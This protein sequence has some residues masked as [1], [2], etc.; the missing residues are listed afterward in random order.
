MERGRGRSCRRR[1]WVHGLSSQCAAGAGVGSWA[2][3]SPATAA[4]HDLP[5]H[6]AYAS[7]SCLNRA[8]LQNLRRKLGPISSQRCRS[9][10]GEPPIVAIEGQQVPSSS[11]CLAM[12]K[13]T[14]IST[15]LRVWSSRMMF[16][17]SANGRRRRSTPTESLCM[18]PSRGVALWTYS[19]ADF[20]LDSSRGLGYS[21]IYWIRKQPPRGDK[22]GPRKTRGFCIVRL[23]DEQRVLAIAVEHPSDVGSPKS[24]A[25]PAPWCDPLEA[26]RIVSTGGKVSK[27]R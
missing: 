2:R 22:H 23:F 9:C 10:S 1:D 16:S 27:G 25:R 6:A 20:L 24:C 17:M 12:A 14:R 26:C 21:R 13:Y 18:V 7:S 19:S 4:T 8:Y 15:P 3:K 5:G 11:A